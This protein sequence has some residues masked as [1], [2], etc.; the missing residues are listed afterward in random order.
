MGGAVEGFAGFGVEGGGGGEAWGFAEGADA[1]SEVVAYGGGLDLGHE[2]AFALGAELADA[3]AA[4]DHDRLAQADR[5]GDV[6]GEGAPAA[7]GEED[8]F[9]VAPLGGAF[10]EVAA[11]GADT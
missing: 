4:L 2:A 7:D 10:V 11:G 3:E 8:L 5:L 9:A 6:V 1:P